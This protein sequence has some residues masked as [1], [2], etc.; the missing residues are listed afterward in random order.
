MQHTPSHSLNILILSDIHLQK[1]YLEKLK[2][3]YL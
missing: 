1:Q 2:I 3:W